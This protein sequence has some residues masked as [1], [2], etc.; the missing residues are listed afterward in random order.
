MSPKNSVC[1]NYKAIYFLPN[2]LVIHHSNFMELC[3]VNVG[4]FPIVV[5][6]NYIRTEINCKCIG[7]LSRSLEPLPILV[8]AKLNENGDN[9]F[10]SNHVDVLVK[11]TDNQIDNFLILPPL[12]LGIPLRLRKII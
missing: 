8:F 7:L 4:W 6:T 3:N 11:S 5:N 12:L 10:T 1:K 9:T 2:S